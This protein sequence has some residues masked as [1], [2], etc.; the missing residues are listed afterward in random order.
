MTS[1]TLE[2]AYLGGAPDGAIMEN[3]AW[4]ELSPIALGLNYTL[5]DAVNTSV[6]KAL[7]IDLLSPTSNL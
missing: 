4:T 5:M 2:I 6:S 1:N 3:V 7:I